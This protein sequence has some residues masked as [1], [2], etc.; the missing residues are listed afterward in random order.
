MISCDWCRSDFGVNEEFVMTDRSEHF[1][2]DCYQNSGDESGIMY[3][4]VENR[5]ESQAMVIRKYT[6]SESDMKK[7]DEEVQRKVAEKLNE[8]KNLQEAFTEVD[9]DLQSE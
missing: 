8:G 1:H 6:K 4:P 5:L 3:V 2:E 7:V 9:Q